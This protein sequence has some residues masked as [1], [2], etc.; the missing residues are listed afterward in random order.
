MAVARVSLRDYVLGTAIGIVPGVVLVVA[1]GESIVRSV[2]GAPLAALAV[3][4]V[5][6]GM[7]VLIRRLRGRAASPSPNVESSRS[8]A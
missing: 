5:I 8:D 4:G 6:A 7:I 2:S 3:F 1:F